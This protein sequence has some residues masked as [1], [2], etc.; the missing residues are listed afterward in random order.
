M[1]CKALSAE[2]NMP[3]IIQNAKGNK[4]EFQ[5]LMWQASRE[6]AYIY[7]IGKF[8]DKSYHETLE[9]FIADYEKEEVCPY[10]KLKVVFL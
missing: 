3:L 6:V 9:D 5:Y 1:S 8:E 2:L 7:H 10:V 4:T